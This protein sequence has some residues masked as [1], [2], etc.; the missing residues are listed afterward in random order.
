VNKIPNRKLSYPMMI[1][2]DTKVSSLHPL[3]LSQLHYWSPIHILLQFRGSDPVA[4]ML[5]MAF[6]ARVCLGYVIL[7]F[8]TFRLKTRLW[9]WCFAL[10]ARRF[11]RFISNT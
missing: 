7:I 2:Y 5:W 9:R 11:S 3:P 6:S 8:P 4:R 1:S 10:S